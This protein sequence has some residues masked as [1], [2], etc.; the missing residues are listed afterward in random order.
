[1]VTAPMLQQGITVELPEVE[2]APIEVT[3]DN[4]PL[5]VS[6]NAAGELFMN[7]GETPDQPI[8]EQELLRRTAAIVTV[9]PN[10]PV[11]IK[12]DQALNLG[13]F[14]R[15]LALLQRAGATG[16]GILTETPDDLPELTPE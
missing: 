1:M 9:N 14:A 4:E 11:L 7:L 3:E 5:I 2:A 16:I 8:T 10:T 12:G 15:V 13:I 6:I